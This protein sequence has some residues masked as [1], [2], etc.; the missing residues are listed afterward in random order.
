MISAPPVRNP[1]AVRPHRRRP[2]RPPTVPLADFGKPPPPPARTPTDWR[3]VARNSA[4]A[5]VL[6]L[7]LAWG[8]MLVTARSEAIWGQTR[9]LDQRVER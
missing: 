4:L 9:Y 7:V 5:A 2:G 3:V 8:I 1:S 6:L